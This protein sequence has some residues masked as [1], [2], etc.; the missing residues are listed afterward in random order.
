MMRS[1]SSN[2]KLGR[3]ENVLVSKF[4]LKPMDRDTEFKM[5]RSRTI[6]TRVLYLS[7]FNRG[8]PTK[9]EIFLFQIADLRILTIF[10]IFDKI[11]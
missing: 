6:K 11:S 1:E 3:L 8:G 7:R 2:Y 5:V 9:F 10:L 4:V